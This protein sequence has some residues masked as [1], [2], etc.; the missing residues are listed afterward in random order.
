MTTEE[1][2]QLD[3]ET[4]FALLKRYGRYHRKEMT[5][6]EYLRRYVP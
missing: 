6:N 3:R 2:S 1:Y 5:F 4:R